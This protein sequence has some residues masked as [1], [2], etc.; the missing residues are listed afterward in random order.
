[1]G[2]RGIRGHPMH[3][4]HATWPLPGPQGSADVDTAHEGGAHCSAVTLATACT[5]NRRGFAKA[6]PEAKCLVRGT[7]ADSG[8]VGGLRRG[9]SDGKSMWVGIRTGKHACLSCS[10]RSTGEGKGGGV[11]FT[12][13]MW[14]TREVW[15]LISA[16][17]TSDGYFQR[18]SWF[19]LQGDR[20]KEG[21]RVME[22]GGE[23]VDL[24]RQQTVVQSC[25]PGA[26]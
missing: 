20:G 3:H 11:Q 19:W 16:I 15:P 21:G 6:L 12:C 5:G 7:S 10:C 24:V 1:M 26:L 23:W 4:R 2:V 17:F 8:A 18:H 14:R 22:G 25:S 13:A 9:P